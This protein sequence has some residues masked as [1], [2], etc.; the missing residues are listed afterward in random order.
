MQGPIKPSHINTERHF[1]EAF[2]N[3]ETET[4][5]QWIVRLCQE[6]GSWQPFSDEE[7]EAFYRRNGQLDGF[8]FNNLLRPGWVVKGDDGKYRVTSEFVAVCY[9]SSPTPESL[10]SRT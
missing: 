7:I 4:S 6:R 10:S 5:A 2:R 8:T 3:L 9:A 1:S